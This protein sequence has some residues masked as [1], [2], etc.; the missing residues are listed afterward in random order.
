MTFLTILEKLSVIVASL[1]VTVVTIAGIFIINQNIKLAQYN[2]TTEEQ[3]EL[4]KTLYRLEDFNDS[5][6]SKYKIPNNVDITKELLAKITEEERLQINT[7][8]SGINASAARMFVVMPDA[9]Y[10]YITY[11]WPVGS[12]NYKDIRE[13][14][15]VAMRKIQDPKT[16]FDDPEDIRL[17][18]KLKRPIPD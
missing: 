3:I 13:S 5:L 14:I 8:V 18:E 17:I 4:V 7:F 10:K 12:F 6:I 16:E 9:K 2:I 11:G 15:L 1:V